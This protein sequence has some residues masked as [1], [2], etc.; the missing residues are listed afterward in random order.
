M[1]VYTQGDVEVTFW[2]RAVNNAGNISEPEIKT[3]TTAA[4]RKSF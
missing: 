1:T 4:F 2:V 3:I